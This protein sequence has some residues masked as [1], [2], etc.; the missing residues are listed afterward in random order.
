M[1]ILSPLTEALL[2]NMILDNTVF[3]TKTST[4]T[5]NDVTIYSNNYEYSNIRAWLN[6]YDGTSYNVDN[7]TNKGFINIAFTEEERKLINT[8]LVDTSL[9]STGDSSNSYICN[10]TND[11]IYLL[12]YAEARNISNRQATVSDYARSK[13]CFMSTDSSYYGNGLWWLRSPYYNLNYTARVVDDYGYIYYDSV[14]YS[15][16]GVRAALEITIE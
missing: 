4:R 6:G 15:Y 1:A 13:Y 11:K 16:S 5:I 10:N 3:Y 12:S 8:T 7:Y 9:A 2:S 14:H